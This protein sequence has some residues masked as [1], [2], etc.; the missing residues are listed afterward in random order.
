M[1]A[2]VS[3]RSERNPGS[4]PPQMKEPALAG[5]RNYSTHDPLAVARGSDIVF[6]QSRWAN[7]PPAEFVAHLE[8]VI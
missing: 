8:S 3:E 2:R 5:D 7:H 1:V 6:I 4:R